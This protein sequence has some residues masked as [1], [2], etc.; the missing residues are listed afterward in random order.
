MAEETWDWSSRSCEVPGGFWHETQLLPRMSL[1]GSSPL[2]GRFPAEAARFSL[3]LL[4]FMI[5]C[6]IPIIPFVADSEWK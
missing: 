5:G 6:M 2:P 4:L 1:V 3:G